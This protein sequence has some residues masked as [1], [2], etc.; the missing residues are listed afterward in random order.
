MSG[1]KLIAIIGI[2]M[3]LVLV[4]A[5]GRMRT[6]PRQRML[7]MAAGWIAIIV[8]VALAFGSARPPAI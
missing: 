5:N 3:A 7:L 1:D 2:V 8:V 6:L 4:G